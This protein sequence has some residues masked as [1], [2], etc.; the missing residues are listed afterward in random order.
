M[1]NSF[2]EHFQMCC[3]LLSTDNILRMFPP[4]SRWGFWNSKGPQ[5]TGRMAK[6][7]QCLQGTPRCNFFFFLIIISH[8]D[9]E[10]KFLLLVVRSL[11]VSKFLKNTLV[12][13]LL[14]GLFGSHSWYKTAW[15]LVLSCWHNLEACC[16]INT[17]LSTR[18]M[19]YNTIYRWALGNDL[20]TSRP[21][22]PNGNQIPAGGFLKAS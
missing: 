11:L 2:L 14:P 21:R 3:F 10:R 12:L 4:P 19:S 8:W 6:W 9:S 16:I 1:H 22:L 18:L 13:F 20:L 5:S 15:D 17:S 7:L